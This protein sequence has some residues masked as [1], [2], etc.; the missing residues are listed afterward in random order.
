MEEKEELDDESIGIKPFLDKFVDDLTLLAKDSLE[1]VRENCAEV[2][3]TAD[4]NLI[5]SLL[6]LLSA[7]FV[8]SNL[9]FNK[10]DNAE[11]VMRLHLCYSIIWSIGG[12]IEDK[13]RIK[14]STHMKQSFM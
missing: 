5:A 3:E 4:C 9:N 8:R 11:V 7:F 12:N 1:Y 14:F 13:S 2:I 10:I 6:K